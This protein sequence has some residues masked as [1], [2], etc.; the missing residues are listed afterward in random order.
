MGPTPQMSKFWAPNPK[1]KKLNFFVIFTVFSLN[2]SLFSWPPRYLHIFS[3]LCEGIPQKRYEGITGR[4]PRPYT[5]PKAKFSSMARLAN[6]KHRDLTA[7]APTG[8]RSCISG[9]HWLFMTLKVYLE[10]RGIRKWLQNFLSKFTSLCRNF[11]M[12][13]NESWKKS[14]NNSRSLQFTF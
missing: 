2:V 12:S 8:F 14:E 9:Y 11:I 1:A 10:F 4:P 7:P 5:Q 6:A 3:N 13:K